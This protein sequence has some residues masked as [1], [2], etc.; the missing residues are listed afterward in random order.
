MKRDAGE[1]L[2]ACL[3][4]ADPEAAVRRSVEIRGHE[5]VLGGVTRIDLREFG[6]VYVVGAGKASAVMAKALEELLGDHV[7]GGVVSVKYGHGVRLRRVQVLEAGHPVP[8]SAGEAAASKIIGLLESLGVH[9]L[10]IACISGGGSALLPAAAAGITLGDKQEVTAALL[11][12]GA[13]IHEMNAVRKHLSRTKGG[14]LMRVAYPATVI[15]L[16]LSDVVGDHWD[17]IASG[18]F[19]PD[20]TTFQDVL[21]ILEGYDILAKVSHLIAV[22]VREGAE[23]RIE[24]NPQ[25]GDP[26]FD[27]VFSLVVGSNIQSLR[28]AAEKARELGYNAVILSSTLEGDTTQAALFHAAVAE[29]ARSTG[30]PISPPAC[31]LSGGETTV[32]IKGSGL[33]G[34]NQH[35]ALSLVKKAST[36]SDALFLS[37]GTDGT[38]GPTDAAGATV[39]ATTLER[40]LN[41]GLDPEAYL[42]DNDSYRFFEKLGDLIVTGPTRTNVMDVRIILL[43]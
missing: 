22:R 7:A 30:N 6:R 13:D 41:L 42:R 10:V 4:A 19:V 33:G 11:A 3:D 36:I 43:A 8:D 25:R 28:A 31:I 24:E 40:A 17:T 9:D 16:M 26:I 12:V 32:V 35:F 27:R 23:G 18:P 14:N 38:D 2:N 20:G 39:D 15:N 34:R 21:R 37:V 29:E 5:L 1:I